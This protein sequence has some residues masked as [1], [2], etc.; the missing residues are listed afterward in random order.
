MVGMVV[1]LDIKVVCRSTYSLQA[2]RVVNGL[3]VCN[4]VTVRIKSAWK[5]KNVIAHTKLIL[6]HVFIVMM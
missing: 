2:G 5:A 6:K 1:F 4:P 3:P